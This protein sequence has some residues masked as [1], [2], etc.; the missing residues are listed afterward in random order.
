MLMSDE[1]CQ[2]WSFN[3]LWILDYGGVAADA[4]YLDHDVDYDTI[5]WQPQIEIKSM[6]IILEFLG[7]KNYLKDPEQMWWVKQNIAGLFPTS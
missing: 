1:N 3:G 6:K 5:L 2:L 7:L 4:S